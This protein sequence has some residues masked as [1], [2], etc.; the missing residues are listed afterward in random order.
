M[1]YHQSVE[2]LI[3]A[4]VTLAVQIEMDDRSV[5]NYMDVIPEFLLQH[6]LRVIAR[7]DLLAVFLEWLTMQEGAA[8]KAVA[9]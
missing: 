6:D 1:N 7:D 5:T 8:P 2:T 9:L 4:A 3:H